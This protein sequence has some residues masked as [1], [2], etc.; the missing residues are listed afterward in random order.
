MRYIDEEL[1]KLDIT[2]I[3]AQTISRGL[4]GLVLVT[5]LAATVAYFAEW[6]VPEWFY[7]LHALR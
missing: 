3:S 4:F 2:D 1:M 7:S 6:N 5:G